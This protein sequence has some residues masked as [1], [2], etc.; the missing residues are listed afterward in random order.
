MA[1]KQDEFSSNMM[2]GT[3]DSVKDRL[4]ISSLNFFSDHSLLND[5][6]RMSSNIMTYT[7]VTMSKFQYNS[8]MKYFSETQAQNFN[9][10]L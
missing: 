7:N 4:R 9:L 3:D 6:K 5:L 2:T 10:E 1:L 8:Q